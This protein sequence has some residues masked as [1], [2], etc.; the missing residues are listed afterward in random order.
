LYIFNKPLGSQ[1]G[2]IK[3]KNKGGYMRTITYLLIVCSLGLFVITASSS[4]QVPPKEILVGGSISL[5]GRFAT[6]VA[7]FQKFDNA[8]AAIVNERGGIFIK[9]YNRKL[10][11]RYIIYDDKSDQATSMKFYEKLIT[12]DKVHILIGPFGSFLSFAASTVAER[13]KIPMVMDSAND[14]RLFE[15]GY[16]WSVVQIDYSDFEAYRYL[17]MIK[18]EGKVKTMVMFSEDTIHSTGVLKASVAKAKELGFEVL[19]E[20]TLPESTKDFSALITKIKG[21]NPDLVFCEAF[22]SFEIPFMK[23]AI[24]LG[25]RPKEFYCG[26]MTKPLADTLGPRANYI[27]S[28]SFWVPGFKYPGKEDYLEALKRTGINWM[29]YQET[30]AR[31]NTNHAIRNAVESAGSLQPE[32]L[33]DALRKQKYVG[34]FGPIWHKPDGSGSA[35]A[36]PIQVQDGKFV[37]IY[38]PEVADGK[39]L[40]PTPW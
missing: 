5:T 38:P 24:E 29:E 30:A 20:E 7:P 27:V 13:Y 21:L 11:I 33:M 39:H 36:L 3:P 26:H 25:L 31:F 9:E 19:L 10:P 35:S 4:A 34:I 17:D 14:K 37:P 15:R 40:F 1:E 18:K 28:I 23:Q 22:A 8:C 2:L 6:M 16:K 32:K 12:D